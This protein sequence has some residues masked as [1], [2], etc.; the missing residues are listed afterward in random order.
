MRRR[1]GN[2]APILLMSSAAA[3]GMFGGSMTRSPVT[4]GDRPDYKVS[5]SIDP[6]CTS[7][8]TLGKRGFKPDWLTPEV[9]PITIHTANPGFTC[10]GNKIT[11]VS[12]AGQTMTGPAIQTGAFEPGMIIVELNNQ[13]VNPDDPSVLAQLNNPNMWMTIKAV[14]IPPGY[15]AAWDANA[16]KVY[17]LNDTDKT[18]SYNPP[19]Q[20][21]TGTNGTNGT[22]D[23]DDSFPEDG[24]EKAGSHETTLYVLVNYTDENPR[25]EMVDGQTVRLFGYPSMTVQMLKWI[26]EDTLNDAYPGD[27]EDI[28][29]QAVAKDDY[30]LPDSMVCLNSIPQGTKLE[31]YGVF[32]PQETPQC[33]C[34]IS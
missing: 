15:R 23:D 32:G 16:R 21:L 18:T 19:P 24:L 11:S 13:P 2:R 26:V 14:R 5:H 22:N 8:Q 30:V 27:G 28:A 20:K 25:L 3:G 29:I 34:T 9:S 1:R 4:G 10:Q 33:V 17:Y 7:G 12:T 31:M 6:A